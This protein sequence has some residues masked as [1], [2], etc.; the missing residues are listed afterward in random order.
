LQKNGV[1]TTNDTA[2][3]QAV[4]AL[5]KNSSATGFLTRMITQQPQNDRLIELYKR[6][7][8]TDAAD[9]AAAQDP[10]VGFRGLQESL[11]NLAADIG[12][13]V[14]PVIVPGLNAL[15]G[16]INSFAAMVHDQDPRVM[17]AAGIAGAGLAAFGTWK[18]TTGLYALATAGPALN[19]AAAALTAAAVAQRGGVPGAGGSPASGGAGWL[20][21]LG[22][23]GASGLWASLVQSM[24]STPGGTFDQQVSNQKQARLG[25][26]RMLG[27]GT[28]NPTHFQEHERD[29][30]LYGKMFVSP[31]RPGGI[32][33]VLNPPDPMQPILDGM[34][35]VNSTPVRP[36]VDVSQ[37][38]AMKA[39]IDGILGGLGSIGGAVT[40][41]S[42]RVDEEVR[43]AHTDF[44]V[45]P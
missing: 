38:Q 12:E 29:D 20:A 39:L 18:M 36:T 7:L 16:V 2:V 28:G 26:R 35:K 24:G 32:A 19:E 45:T 37:L 44:G 40:K 27:L 43:R 1:D 33:S 31:Q 42:G 10:I 17:G 30:S 14:M 11:R 23:T 3:A 21:A 13:S 6:G 15:S 41:A 9:S 4:A 34:E 5:S 8:G 25:L 22:L